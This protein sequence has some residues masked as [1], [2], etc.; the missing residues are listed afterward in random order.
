MDPVSGSMDASPVSV[1]GPA[2]PVTSRMTLGDEVYNIFAQ[3]DTHAIQIGE[4]DAMAAAR[5]AERVL[6]GT[7]VPPCDASENMFMYARRIFGLLKTKGYTMHSAATRAR[8][9]VQTASMV[10]SKAVA[11][12]L[13]VFMRA[14]AGLATDLETYQDYNQVGNIMMNVHQSSNDTDAVSRLQNIQT[15]LQVVTSYSLVKL[16]EEFMKISNESK[17]TMADV[18]EEDTGTTEF[19][20]LVAQLKETKIL[21]S[22]KETTESDLVA[23]VK[24]FGKFNRLV[25]SLPPL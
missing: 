1:S 21:L 6:G 18:A 13:V 23:Q 25:A 12:R 7:V 11:H 9:H 5:K 14:I 3:T 17:T 16:P 19:A 10:P 4:K 8:L 2:V 22:T 20:A 24:D 15:M